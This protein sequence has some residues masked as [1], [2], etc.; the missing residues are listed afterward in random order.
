MQVGHFRLDQGFDEPIRL[1]GQQQVI[2]VNDQNGVVRKRDVFQKN[3]HFLQKERGIRTAKQRQFLCT[4]RIDLSN[5]TDKALPKT[6]DQI[7]VQSFPQDESTRTLDEFA[8]GCSFAIP[9]RRFHYG[10][11]SF[12][13]PAQVFT[14]WLAKIQGGGIVFGHKKI[15]LC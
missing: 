1:G 9:H 10:E 2:V 4:I 11:R 12:Q 7:A 6:A 13:N 8:D 14:H 3:E 15:S 5:Q